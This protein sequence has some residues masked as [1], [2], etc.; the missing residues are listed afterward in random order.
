MDPTEQFFANNTPAGRPPARLSNEDCIKQNV[1]L[2][3][4]KE[5]EGWS[6]EQ[7]A[8]ANTAKTG[9]PISG[10]TFRRYFDRAQRP[11]TLRARRL[12]TKREGFH[13]NPDATVIEHD[14]GETPPVNTFGLDREG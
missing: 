3:K 13:R 5:K 6:D 4:K 12:R 8:A 2:F 14:A 10:Q 7:M 9:R 11:V 1:E